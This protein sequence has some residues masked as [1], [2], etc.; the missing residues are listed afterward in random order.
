MMKLLYSASS[1]NYIKMKRDVENI[2]NNQKKMA[3]R[4]AT[5]LENHHTHKMTDVF[6]IMSNKDEL[7]KILRGDK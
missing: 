3:Q 2:K 7:S 1:D 5:S 4:V 6:G